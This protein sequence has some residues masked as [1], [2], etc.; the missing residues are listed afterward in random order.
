MRWPLALPTGSEFMPP[1]ERACVA[2]AFE[3]NTLSGGERSMLSVLDA[4]AEL[5]PRIVA[6][7]SPAAGPLTLVSY[8]AVRPLRAYVEPL[9][10]GSCLTPMPLFLTTTHYINIPL[11]ETYQEAWSGVPRRWQRV[12]EGKS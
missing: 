1:I 12:V 11:E 10:M 8:A 5:F 6:L 2:L 7:V 9:R 4:R 3:Y